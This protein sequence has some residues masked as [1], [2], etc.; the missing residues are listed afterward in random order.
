MKQSLK[1]N[2]RGRFR[3]LGPDGSDRTPSS[4]KGR[5]LLAILALSPNNTRSRSWLQEKLWS[6][7][8]QALGAASLR[9]CLSILR[10]SFGPYKDFL[11]TDKQVISIRATVE[12]GGEGSFLEDLNVNDSEF[13]SWRADQALLNA[14]LKQPERSIIPDSAKP[15]VFSVL[16]ESDKDARFFSALVSDAVIRRLGEAG[17]IEMLEATDMGSDPG[18]LEFILRTYAMKQGSHSGVRIRLE[19]AESGSIIWTGHR[20]LRSDSLSEIATVEVRRLMNHAVDAAIDR[21]SQLRPSKSSE[22]HSSALCFRAVAKMFTLNGSD[23]RESEDM[24]SMASD[25]DNRGIYLAWRAY[26]KIIQFAERIVTDRESVLEETQAL[27]AHAL[28]RGADNSM[29]LALAS[30][31]QSVIFKNYVAGSELAEQSLKISPI[32]PMAWAFW[33]VA[34]MH[35]GEAEDSFRCTTYA[36]EI[37][38]HGPQKYQINMLACQSAIVAGRFVEAIKLAETTIGMAPNYAPPKRYLAAL[39]VNADRELDAIKVISDLRQLEPDFS[40][41]QLADPAYPASALRLSPL[42]DWLDSLSQ[43]LS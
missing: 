33:G 1:I 24:L 2:V 18:R 41:D 37:S 12:T 19:A 15:R 29:V 8:T 13:K 16:D 7:Q 23:L 36:R 27:I 32:N 43:R 17:S 6:Q 4:K 35:L 40:F 5:A 31:V 34:K 28:E 26:L 11:K 42:G 14:V 25:L 30:Y 3:V 22:S 38:G 20:V 21:Y 10:K 39:L 9:Q